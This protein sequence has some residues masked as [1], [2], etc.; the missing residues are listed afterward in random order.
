MGT[1][2]FC[3]AGLS[4]IFLQKDSEQVGM[5]FQKTMS[6]NIITI[7]FLDTPP[8]LRRG[9]SFDL[10]LPYWDPSQNNN[11]FTTPIYVIFRCLMNEKYCV[12]FI[13]YCIIFYRRMLK[14]TVGLTFPPNFSQVNLTIARNKTL[15]P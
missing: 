11:A 7:Y 13:T 4:S 15:L 1:P 12:H 3:H 6:D 2:C 5:T 9:G 8:S 10:L 14:L